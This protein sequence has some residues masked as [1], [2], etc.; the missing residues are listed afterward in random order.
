MGLW[1]IGANLIGNQQNNIHMTG[2][3]SVALDGNVI[4]TAYKHNILAENCANL[5]LTGNNFDQ[6]HNMSLGMHLRFKN[7]DGITMSG[8]SIH[9]QTGKEAYQQTLPDRKA[10][11]EFHGCKRIT[12]T[13]NQIANPAPRGVAFNACDHV[14]MT[15]CLVTDQREVDR[16]TAAVVIDAKSKDGLIANNNFDMGTKVYVEKAAGSDVVERDNLHT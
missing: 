14:N 16:M 4:Y 13:G 9:D 6:Y 5:S 11:V 15:G 3:R 2:C 7:C 12:L 8:N 1:T 10:T